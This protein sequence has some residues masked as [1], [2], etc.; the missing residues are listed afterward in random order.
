MPIIA[1]YVSHCLRLSLTLLAGACLALPTSLAQEN[2]AN[3]QQKVAL[4]GATSDS[5]SRNASA[6]AM[7]GSD[8]QAAQTAFREHL[9]KMREAQVKYHLS[10]DTSNDKK[11]RRQWAELCDQGRPLAA[12]AYAVML[13]KF[14]ENPSANAQIGKF[15]AELLERNVLDSR[16]EGMLEKDSPCIPPDSPAR[17]YLKRSL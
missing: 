10:E 12:K 11:F 9:K 6:D 8:F 1:N 3:S 7:E 16:F 2:T 17:R 13:K 14:T 4:P 15:L 5:A